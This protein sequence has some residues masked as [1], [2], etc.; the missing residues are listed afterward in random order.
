M[1]ALE[2]R[3]AF[4]NDWIGWTLDALRW[5]DRV[6]QE[7]TLFVLVERLPGKK[8]HMKLLFLDP[9]LAADIHKH[10][11]PLIVRDREKHK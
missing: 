9:E 5:V 2:N 7:F 11:T 6:I 8:G 10:R 3:V 1:G 4:V